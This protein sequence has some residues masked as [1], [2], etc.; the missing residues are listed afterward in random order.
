MHWFKHLTRARH[1]PFIWDLRQRFGGEGYFVY[2][3]TLEIYADSFKPAPGWFLD[4]SLAYLKHE[5]GIY[6]G[7]KLS[8]ILDFIRSWPE[9]DQAEMVGRSGED[10]GQIGDRSAEDRAPCSAHL[11]AIY[12]KWIVNL[13]RD[14]ILILIP[15]FLKIMD[16]YTKKKLRKMGDMAGQWP[17]DA[18]QD[19]EEK[20][21]E[22]KKNPASEVYRVFAD[23]S[24]ACETLAGF[25]PLRGRRFPGDRFVG[26]CIAEGFHPQA[27]RD[28]T[29]ALIDRYQRGQWEEVGDPWAYAKGT[30]KSRNQFY[31]DTIDAA[32]V[33]NVFGRFFNG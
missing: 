30:V 11:A 31:A 19:P 3:A 20:R 26:R 1:D 32:Q 29:A 27:I 23:I 12:P 8:Q 24:K 4:V 25:P 21:G 17:D 9:I 15:N 22:K 16:E 28:G 14:R 13:K 6:H 7:K 33:K 2:F 10:D 18:P 5:L